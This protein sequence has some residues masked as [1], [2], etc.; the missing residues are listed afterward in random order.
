MTPSDARPTLAEPRGLV[1][2]DEESLRHSLGKALRRAGYVVET[3]AT[4]REGVDL[5]RARPFDAVVTDVRLPDL[6]GL[7]VVALITETCP[8]TA[9]LVMTGFGTVDSALEAMR[10]GARDFVTKP[11][12]TAD[13]LV[14]LAR[15]VARDRPA[16]SETQ[17]RVQVERTFAPEGY[18]QVDDELRRGPAPAKSRAET[19]PAPPAV[20]PAVPLGETP[21]AGDPLALREAQRQFEVRYVQDLLARTGGNVAAAARLAGINRPNFHKKLKVLG[22]DPTRFKEAH[23]RGRTAGL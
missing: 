15:E 22:V 16:E 20:E 21:G 4:G 14:R 2:D 19:R 7:D 12:E 6:S 3:A 8:R 23:R 5:L 17:L 9:V 11:F 13:L 1:S 18:A 10:R